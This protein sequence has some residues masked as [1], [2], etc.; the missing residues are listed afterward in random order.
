MAYTI[1]VADSGYTF[2][3]ASCNIA[4]LTVATTTSNNFVGRSTDDVPPTVSLIDPP[5]TYIDDQSQVSFRWYGADNV[6]PA[7]QI[8]YQYQLL[9]SADTGWSTWSSGTS[10]A[11]DLANGVYTFSVRAEDLAGNITVVPATETFAVSDVPRIVA[12]QLLDDGLWLGEFQVL[13]PAGATGISNQVVITPSQFGLTGSDFVPL[14]LYP[15]GSQTAIGTINYAAQQLDLPAVFQ[16]AAVGFILTLPAPIS[17]GQ[18]VGYVVQWAQGANMGWQDPVSVPWAAP[19]MT[20]VFGTYL[21]QNL[22]LWRIGT[23][24][25]NP[26]ASDPNYRNAYLYVQVSD[27]SGSVMNE[28][29][30]DFCPASMSWYG[31]SGQYLAPGSPCF[32]ETPTEIWAFWDLNVFTRIDAIN[33]TN[34]RQFGFQRFDK[35]TLQP[36]GQPV[37]SK[38]ALYDS[39]CC[40]TLSP[41]GNVWL[42]DMTGAHQLAYCRINS[43]GTIVSQ[44]ANG[45]NAVQITNLPSDES[46]YSANLV[47][48]PDGKVWCFYETY[49]R[50]SGWIYPKYEEYLTILNPDGSTS[51]GPTPISPQVPANYTGYQGMNFAMP[52]VNKQGKVW[53]SFTYQFGTPSWSY[54]YYYTVFD[55]QGTPVAGEDMVQTPSL[56]TFSFVDNDG[57]IWSLQGGQVQILNPDGTPAEPPRSGNTLV[58][59]QA[60]G[61]LAA[62][63]TGVGYQLFDRWSTQSVEVSVPQQTYVG[64]MEVVNADKYSQR[65][66]C[67]GP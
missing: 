48:T 63:V 38:Q 4:D 33:F 65:R 43:A 53:T 28:R 30:V 54:S 50:D 10:V 25:D 44:G 46:I 23:S 34:Y 57:Y 26:G 51:S 15:A 17:A 6:T 14:R 42:L 64:S 47:V 16:T 62:I 21:D 45:S 66:L 3:P 27:A 12:P 31:S 1:T 52:V 35:S 8:R 37:Y 67:G 2:L 11:Y 49:Q 13:A 32:V 7:N 22:R 58:P 60:V 55:S 61:T 39:Y 18:T 41:D 20:T 59:N 24:Q 5:P 9:G 29:L 19:D 40:P 56:R 36:I